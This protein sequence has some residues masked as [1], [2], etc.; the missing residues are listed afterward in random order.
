MQQVTIPSAVERTGLAAAALLLSLT[1]GVAQAG[2]SGPRRHAEGQYDAGTATYSVAKGDDLIAIGK[3]FDVSVDALKA[4]N[5]LISDDIATGQRLIIATSAGGAT[6]TETDASAAPTGPTTPALPKPPYIYGDAYEAGLAGFIYGMPL[7]LMDQTMR[8]LTHTASAGQYSAPMNQLSWMKT[9]VSPEFKNVVRVSLNGL[10][11]FASV[12]LDQGPVVLTVPALQG[13]YYVAQVLDMWTNDFASI[14]T[15]T[16]GPGNFLIAGPGWDGK[17][18]P[19]IK[20]TYRS[21]TRYAWILTQIQVTGPDDYPATNEIAAQQALTPLSAWDKP[22]TPP[23][24][25]PVETEL[26]TADTPLAQVQS[27][28]TQAFFQRLAALMVDNP[29][30]PADKP[31]LEALKGIGVEPGMPFDID[32]LPPGVAPELERAIQEGWALLD[33]AILTMPTV[34]GW[35]NPQNLGAYGTDYPTRAVVA[36][37]GLG[38]LTA[39]DAVYPTAFHDGA[40]AL[41]DFAKRYVRRFEKDEMPPCKGP[42]SISIYQGNYY[43]TSPSNPANKFGVLSGD[44][45]KYNADGSLDLYVQPSSPGADLEA[46][47]LPS[48]PGG[49]MNLS[50][51]CYWPEDSI[52]DGA[53]KVPPLTL[54]D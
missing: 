44:A 10:W 4:G 6:P 27:M 16:T 52:K 51:R 49:P 20:Q 8:V 33:T 50:V 29:P 18:P 19:D 23:V 25:V 46:N 36:W 22:Y 13:R 37:L 5:K 15:R 9:Q 34:N 28:S 47:W 2:D 32:A 39:D 26:N 3:R 53:Y 12:D 31:M 1:L 45:F 35:T 11:S 43:T 54:V 24:Y 38:A 48:P 7:V 30:A 40:G 41:L 42:W 21:T 14:G 17:A